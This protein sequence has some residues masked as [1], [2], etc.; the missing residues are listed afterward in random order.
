MAE[1]KVSTS[2]YLTE[3]QNAALRKLSNATRVSFAA[4]VREG[5]DLILK[6]YAA[7]EEAPKPPAEGEAKEP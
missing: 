6:K 1:R 5:V 7:F 2:V 3:E 4:Y